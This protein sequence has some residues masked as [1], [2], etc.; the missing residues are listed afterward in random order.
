M[1]TNPAFGRAERGVVMDAIASKDPHRAIVHLHWKVN[2]Q[3]A[4]GDTQVLGNP[5][6]NG[7]ITDRLVKLPLGNR[8]G[9][10][11]HRVSSLCQKLFFYANTHEKDAHSR[12]TPC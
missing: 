8:V 2:S 10:F 4:F 6:F 7:E 11:D 9:V 3:F 1:V 12:Q 5:S